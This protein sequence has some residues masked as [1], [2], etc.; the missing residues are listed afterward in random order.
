MELMEKYLL[1]DVIIGI[2]IL[3]E[4][5][6]LALNIARSCVVNIST[7]SRQNLIARYPKNG[8]ASLVSPI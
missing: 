2:I 8:L 4:P 3:I 1:T 5:Y 6:A 7:L